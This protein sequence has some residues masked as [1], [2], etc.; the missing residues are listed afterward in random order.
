MGNLGAVDAGMEVGREGKG[1]AGLVRVLRDA[2]RA[3]RGNA[4]H[5]RS[6]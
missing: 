6:A 5:E 1:G 3:E 4:V 2:P